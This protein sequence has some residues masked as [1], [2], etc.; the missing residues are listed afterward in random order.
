V[1]SQPELKFAPILWPTVYFIDWRMWIVECTASTVIELNVRHTAWW[2]RSTLTPEFTSS[3][4]YF[5]V[6]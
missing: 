3:T 1:L 6:I 2:I 5:C 4:S